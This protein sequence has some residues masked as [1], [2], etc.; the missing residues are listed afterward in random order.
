MSDVSVL[1]PDSYRL[2]TKVLWAQ[3]KKFIAVVFESPV[4]VMEDSAVYLMSDDGCRIAVVFRGDSSAPSHAEHETDDVFAA[5]VNFFDATRYGVVEGPT[6]VDRF[7]VKIGFVKESFREWPR[8]TKEVTYE[9]RHCRM[10]YDWDLDNSYEEDEES[11]S[12][13]SDTPSNADDDECCAV[14]TCHECGDQYVELGDT[15]PSGSHDNK[16]EAR[17][18]DDDATTLLNSLPPLSGPGAFS[19][20]V[21]R[22][23]THNDAPA[24]NSWLLYSAVFIGGGMSAVAL[25]A[26]SIA[27][28]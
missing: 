14:Q 20:D 7:R 25:F 17:P 13:G 8:L 27:R 2:P 3:R 28:Q 15:K 23:A 26:A 5:V 21:L 12:S 4:P 11:Q 19:T 16:D 10:E 22:P 9:V 6:V 1:L 18:S 24:V